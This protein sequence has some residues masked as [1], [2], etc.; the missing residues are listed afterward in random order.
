MLFRPAIVSLGLALTSTKFYPQFA[1]LCKFL[2]HNKHLFL[3]S[4]PE[5][6][7]L[8]IYLIVQ[9]LIIIEIKKGLIDL[10]RGMCELG[11]GIVQG[12]VLKD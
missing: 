12:L 6:I 5:K 10:V 2:S 8:K 9:L 3:I 11:L 4:I 1:D 7:L